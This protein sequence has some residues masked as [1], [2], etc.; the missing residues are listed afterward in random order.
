MR[1][2]FFSR[3][4]DLLHTRWFP[5]LIAV[6]AF[7]DMFLVVVPPDLLVITEAAA[8]PRRSRLTVVLAAVAAALGAV[9]LAVAIR[10]GASM[11]SSGGAPGWWGSAQGYFDRY[12]SLA[13]FLGVLLP[14]PVQPFVGAAVLAGMP[15]SGIF[16]LVLAGRSVKYVVLALLPRLA[17]AK[18]R[19]AS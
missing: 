4:R 10:A 14:L 18:Y 19:A 2:R 15:L 17:P 16:A 3:I 7:V 9:A 12:G 1:A 11:V 5:W 13:L 8:N 6:V